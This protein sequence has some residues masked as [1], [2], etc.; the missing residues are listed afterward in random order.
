MDIVIIHGKEI[1]SVENLQNMLI[2]KLKID[3]KFLED[4]D[5]M[6]DGLT[7]AAKLPLTI[8]WRDFLES[9]EVLGD[10]ADQLMNLMFN[11]EEELEELF[12]FVLKF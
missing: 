1:M 9:R 12:T 2:E 10:Y 8:E 11:V 3:K 7:S 5:S 6:W 4:M